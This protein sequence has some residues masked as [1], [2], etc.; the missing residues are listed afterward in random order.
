MATDKAGNTISTG[1]LYN[2]AGIV[3]AIDSPASGRC[4]VVVGDTPIH[5]DTADLV[6]PAPP[7]ELYV[8]TGTGTN[9]TTSA[10]TMNLST[11]R[12][13]NGRYSLSS[14]QVT[15]AKAGQYWFGLTVQGFVDSESGSL[16]GGL[17]AW[18]EDDTVALAQS[19]CECYLRET[20]HGGS[21]ASSFG[22]SLGAG[23]VLRIRAQLDASIDASLLRS[24]LSIMQVGF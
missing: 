22:A 5:V 3:R 2:V 24:Q 18:L 4:L 1:D 14:N 19:Y 12:E 20:V 16:R 17:E 15:V 13:A 21:A 11:E 9:L 10:A 6:P 23:S 7:P 8:V